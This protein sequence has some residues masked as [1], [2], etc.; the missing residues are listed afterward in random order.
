[1]RRTQ[2]WCPGNYRLSRVAR[3]RTPDRHLDGLVLH[4][5]YTVPIY[6]GSV[7][8]QWILC[9]S[10]PSETLQQVQYINKFIGIAVVV[11][12]PVPTIQTVQKTLEVLQ[13][14][15]HDRVVDILVV[16][17]P[18][19]H[20]TGVATVGLSF[21]SLVP[22]VFLDFLVFQFSPEFFLSRFS[23][24]GLMDWPNSRL[25]TATIFPW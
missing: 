1:M 4:Y 13:I 16:I 8:S 6:D 24:A 11:Q 2:C 3:F 10:S 12:R 21:W 25:C 5:T 14:Q 15:C 9:R 22:P 18:F 19:E 7:L 20:P 17:S 23:G